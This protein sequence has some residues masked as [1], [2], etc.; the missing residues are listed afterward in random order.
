MVKVWAIYV[1]K[2]GVGDYIVEDM[3]RGGLPN[4]TDINFTDSSKESTAT[5]L[6]ENMRSFVCFACSCVSYV[7]AIGVE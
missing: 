7:D 2:T 5:A 4:I 3:K 6:K 1:D